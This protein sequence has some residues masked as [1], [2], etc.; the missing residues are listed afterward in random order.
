LP[1]EHLL[2]CLPLS[3]KGIRQA[4]AKHS[5]FDCPLTVL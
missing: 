2:A 5:P 4:F 1:N 3:E